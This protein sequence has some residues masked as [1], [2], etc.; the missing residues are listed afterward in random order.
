MYTNDWK[1]LILGYYANG[2]PISS[3]DDIPW[4][5]CLAAYLPKTNPENPVLL[6]PA[7]P[8]LPVPV[9]A[10]PTNNTGS[11]NQPYDADYTDPTS[12]KWFPGRSGYGFNL[13]L[14]FYS[15]YTGNNVSTIQRISQMPQGGV[16]TPIFSDANWREIVPDN[17]ATSNPPVNPPANLVGVAGVTGIARACMDRHSRAVNVVFGD[18]HAAPVRLGDLWNLQ[19]AP[20]PG[21]GVNPGMV[22]RNVL[23]YLPAAYW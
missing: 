9:G 23:S 19:W 2:M 3:S 5:A 7:A 18:G 20:L 8:D 12:G 13:A 16:F 15:S 21:P 6:C 14:T 11:S 1:G 4:A 17:S 10:P 22:P